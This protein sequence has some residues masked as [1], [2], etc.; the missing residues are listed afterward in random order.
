M[1]S[2]AKWKKHNKR[3]LSQLS[4]FDADFMIEQN[5]HGAQFKNTANTVGRNTSLNDTNNLTQVNSSQ[6]D[7]HTL[8][9]NIVETVRSE[10]GSAMTT[11]ETRVQDEVKTHRKIGNS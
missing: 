5:N 2:T 8:A 3:L 10:V 9:K 11:V 7:M 6:T 1:F 4:E